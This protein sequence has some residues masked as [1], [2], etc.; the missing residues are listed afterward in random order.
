MGPSDQNKQHVYHHPDHHY[1]KSGS[2][3]QDSKNKIIIFYFYWG[4]AAP[5]TPRLK[6]TLGL[7]NAISL[8]LAGRN[9]GRRNDVDVRP[10]KWKVICWY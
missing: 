7:G 1:L 10:D 6:K 2:Y 5:K 8:M 3:H 9:T 4:A